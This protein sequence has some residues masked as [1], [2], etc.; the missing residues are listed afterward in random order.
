MILHEIDCNYTYIG[1]MKYNTEGEMILDRRHA[2]ER[3]KEKGVVPTQQV[4]DNKISA[5]YRQEIKQTSI[6]FKIVP[7]DDHWRNLEEKAIQTWKE[8]FIGVMSGTAAAFPVHL[9][10]Q[11][12]PQSER[13][14]LLL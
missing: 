13:R 5:E 8:H 2:L 4:V 9:W 7:T 14:L 12:I 10:F 11:A 1:T 6:T 3:M